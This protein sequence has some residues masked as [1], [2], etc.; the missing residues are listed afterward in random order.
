MSRERVAEV[1]H[2]D[3][4]ERRLELAGVDALAAPRARQ[5]RLA[6]RGC[7]GSS[8]DEPLVVEQRGRA[9]DA[10]GAT[11]P[12]VLPALP[13]RGSS[14]SA[15]DPS[16]AEQPLRA[17]RLRSSRLSARCSSGSTPRSSCTTRACGSIS[18]PRTF[19]GCAW[20]C[21]GPVPILRAARPL[22][23]PVLVGAAARRAARGWAAHSG[24]RRDVGRA[25]RVTCEREVEQLEQPERDR[26]RSRWSSALGRGAQTAQADRARRADRASATT[27]C[28]TRWRRRARG[29]HVRRARSRCASSPRTEFRAPAQDRRAAGAGRDVTTSCTGR[30]SRASAPATRPSWPRPRSASPRAGSS[31][32]RRRCRTCSAPTRTRSSPRPGCGAC[33]PTA[34]GSGAAFAAGRL[35]ERERARRRRGPGRAARRPGAELDRAAEAALRVIVYLVRHATGAATA[36]AGRATTTPLRPLDDRGPPAGRGRSSSCSAARDFEPDRLQPVRPLRRRPV[37]PLADGS[38]A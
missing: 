17:R 6:A 2:Y 8:D 16:R 23:D 28:S 32:G 30:G 15:F 24:R 21:A 3:L 22:L 31:S 11:S 9:C 33:S 36:R 19:T 5:G 27:G 20:R 37:V 4:P 13:A 29:P 34:A 1:A 18:I 38:W 12:A 7:R 10:A 35:V 14:P 25:D 26:G